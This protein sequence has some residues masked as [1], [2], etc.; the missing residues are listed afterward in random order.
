MLQRSWLLELAKYCLVLF[1]LLLITLLSNRFHLLVNLCNSLTLNKSCPL[2]IDARWLRGCRSLDRCSYLLAEHFV[3]LLLHSYA[4]V[5]LNDAILEEDLNL[6][7]LNPLVLSL[8][9]TEEVLWRLL[10][11]RVRNRI[12][13]H[14]SCG[15]L[16]LWTQLTS[17]TFLLLVTSRSYRRVA[18][19]VRLLVSSESFQLS[20]A[21][22][23]QSVRYGHLVLTQSTELGFFIYFRNRF[24]HRRGINTLI[25][26][27]DLVRYQVMRH[28]CVQVIVDRD[29]RVPWR[30]LYETLFTLKLHLVIIINLL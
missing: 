15:F 28:F 7:F 29:R 9:W 20:L 24:N 22:G 23:K 6:A 2:L 21:L 1:L 16:L 3:D 25:L 14:H 13:I 5:D 10:L 4:L 18:D 8:I 11:Q 30:W 19:I 27:P 12:L 26:A 17:L